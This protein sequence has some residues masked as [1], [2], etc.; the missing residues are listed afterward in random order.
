MLIDDVRA[1]AIEQV[2]FTNEDLEAKVEETNAAYGEMHRATLEFQKA[3]EGAEV[4]PTSGASALVKLAGKFGNQKPDITPDSAT[5]TKGLISA[6]YT[7]PSA[8]VEAAAEG[9]FN[10]ALDFIIKAK[11]LNAFVEALPSGQ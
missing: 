4:D 6:I 10:T 11:E 3:A 8:E 7:N 1:L 5:E 2:N 9:L